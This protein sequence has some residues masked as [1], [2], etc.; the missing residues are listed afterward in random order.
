MRSARV[1]RTHSQSLLTWSFAPIVALLVLA[2]AVTGC[3]SSAGTTTGGGSTSTGGATASTTATANVG[4]GVGSGTATPTTPAP[5]HAFAWYQLDSSQVPQ[6]WASLNGGASQQITHVAPDHAACVDQVA[7]GLPVFSPDLTH[8]VSSLGSYNCGDG[9]LTGQVAIVNVS[10][11]AITTVPTGGANTTISL[12]ERTAGWVDNS[13]I[14]YVDYAGLYTFA[15]GAGSPTLVSALNQPYDAVLR[16]STLFWT[17]FAT[18]SGSGGA[19]TL[20]R[21]NISTHTDLGFVV[22]LGTTTTCHC[23][24]GD[25]MIPG[26][27]ASPDGSHIVYQV[28]T[29]SSSGNLNEVGSSH[30]YYANADGSGASQ[31]ASYVSTS[32]LARMQISPNGQLVAISTALPSPSVITASVSSPGHNGDPNLH[33]YSP[34]GVSFPVWKWDSATFWTAHA[35]PGNGTGSGATP[36]I[37]H[38]SVGAASGSLGVAGGYNPW[39][40]IGA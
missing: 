31:I 24:A 36:N 35:E 18:T 38:Y 29:P 32:H 10:S 2:L 1:P 9:G 4:D 15:L 27:D 12:T 3:S 28:V 21:F 40:T 5:A 33:F 30:F 11:G 39:Y 17:E 14:W 34:D 19:V 20:H 22:G 37:E 7:W 23:S 16:G 8:I 26:W 25:A 13:T 6:I